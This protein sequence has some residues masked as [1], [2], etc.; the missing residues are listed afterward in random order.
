MKQ[1]TKG[2][3]TLLALVLALAMVMG[4]A[5]SALAD[6]IRVDNG[7]VYLNG[8]YDE[9]LTQKLKLEGNLEGYWGVLDVES[10]D[11]DE[12]GDKAQPSSFTVAGDVKAEG[13]AVYVYANDGGTASAEITGAVTATDIETDYDNA[14]AYAVDGDSTGKNSSTDIHAA[15]GATAEAASSNDGTYYTS[16]Y[17][18]AYAVEATSDEGGSTT[19][20]VDQKA[21]AAASTKGGSY[22]NEA[23]AYAVYA[24]SDEGS[25]TEVTVNG[26]ASATATAEGKNPEASAYAVYAISDDEGKTTVT[27]N[28]D[29][30]ASATV[31]TSSTGWS[32]NAQAIA[33]A[34][35]SEDGGTAEVT[36]T[37]K[38]SASATASGEDAFAMAISVGATA[39]GENSSSSVTV[40]GGADGL[41]AGRALMGGSVTVDI[42]G[43]TTVNMDESGMYMDELSMMFGYSSAGAS[44]IAEGKDA[45]VDFTL[46]GAL[47]VSGEPINPEYMPAV[48][49]AGFTAADEASFK[50]TITGEIVTENTDA[51]N[52]YAVGMEIR[53]LGA[54][55][56]VR[57]DAAEE[58]AVLATGG[59]DS[60]GVIVNVDGGMMI[61]G[62]TVSGSTTDIDLSQ[63][64]GRVIYVNEDGGMMGMAYAIGTGEETEYYIIGFGMGSG[65]GVL[66]SADPL[67][68]AVHVPGYK[69]EGAE[70]VIE[71]GSAIVDIQGD[72]TGEGTGVELKADKK[73]KANVIVD[74]TVSG[75]RANIVLIGDTQLD[76][77]V[78]LTVW[79][80]VPDEN[81]AIIYR[82]ETDPRQSKNG[83]EIGPMWT[84]DPE[85]EDGEG[86]KTTALTADKESEKKLQYIIRVE[87]KTQ[88][89]LA[90]LD[91][92]RKVAGIDRE[93]DVAKEGETVT[94]KLNIPEGYEITGAYGDVDK[95]VKLEKDANGNYFLTVPRGGGVYLAVTLTKIPDPEPDP[96]P[97]PEPD[98]PDTVAITY[99]LGNDTQ[100]DH[101]RTTAAVG[102]GVAL[103]PA[104]ERDGYTFLYW[105]CT[106]V[107]PSSSYYQAPDPEND[108]QFRPGA[109]YTARKDINFVAVW[110]KN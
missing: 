10:F 13:D 90:S 71:S 97:A 104:P 30:K 108:F 54:D 96:E 67:L 110:Q 91:G 59:E 21:D 81:D 26:P 73:Q 58:S 4:T 80:V 95:K 69:I 50:A 2:F 89:Y 20:T 39:M 23:K 47:N 43:D 86:T 94:M 6:Y 40:G 38:A 49:G 1:R 65:S 31:A 44:F 70:R 105:Q 3:R 87:D 32:D 52:G 17:V 45:G 24:S 62:G 46:T 101:I 35:S 75:D 7:K 63:V 16:N 78:T 37:G 22:D 107:D 55:M 93:Y 92:A 29:A 57:I 42:T 82:A 72:V 68:N 48:T 12:T 28:G 66:G 41:I 5:L 100:Y 98:E 76:D 27:V 60:A 106:D 88:Q 51:E 8:E 109:I 79:Q 64:T 85:G 34:A 99:I 15:G 14:Y 74:G 102:E 84:S 9:T 11:D 19:V 83:G 77:N 53:S 33:V 61:T 56:Q 18:E 103:Q 36:V 25:T